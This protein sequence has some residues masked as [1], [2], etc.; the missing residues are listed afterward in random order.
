MNR[1][2][3]PKSH[4]RTNTALPNSQAEIQKRIANGKIIWAGPLIMLS[5]RTIIGLIIMALVVAIFFRGSADPWAKVFLWWR[6]YGALVGLC[7]ISLIIIGPII[8]AFSEDNTYIGYS[9]ARIEALNE[10][11]KWLVVVIMWFFISLQHALF[12]FAGLAWQVVV[13]WFIVL[14]PMT[15][16]YCWLYWRL[17][18]L[19]PM[20]WRMLPQC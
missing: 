13:S 11:R 9:L 4:C 20:C 6:V 14:I 5:S 19:L 8:W 2:S 7:L 15:V 16:F 1:T 10:G 12:P 17:G 3:K 18:R